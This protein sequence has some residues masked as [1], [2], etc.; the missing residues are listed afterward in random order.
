MVDASG[1]PLFGAWR[2]EKLGVVEIGEDL[3]ALVPEVV[4]PTEET[5]IE[6]A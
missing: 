4:G 3:S 2:E 1:L 5:F 6:D